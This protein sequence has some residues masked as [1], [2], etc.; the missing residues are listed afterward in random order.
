MKPRTWALALPVVLGIA[1]MGAIACGDD[2]DENGDD[3]TSAAATPTSAAEETAEATE[4]AGAATEPAGG[5]SIAVTAADFSFSPADIA[6]GLGISIV[7]ELENAGALPHTLTVYEDDTFTTR[8]ASTGNVSPGET[9]DFL[10]TF[11]EAG[12]YPFRCDI[13][14]Q[15]RGTLTVE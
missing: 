12:T 6:G 13:H 7:V 1:L 10:A 15:M 11:I 4:P 3:E 9:G 5:A 8:A 14:T 2:T